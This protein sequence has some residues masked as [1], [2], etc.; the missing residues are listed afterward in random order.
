M[1]VEIAILDSSWFQHALL[2]QTMIQIFPLFH[3]VSVLPGEDVALGAVRHVHAMVVGCRQEV[4]GK[5]SVIVDDSDDLMQVMVQNGF[6]VV[7][8]VV[9][10]CQKILAIDLPVSK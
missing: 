6:H 2:D 3:Q 10:Y 7:A 8:T 1:A 4:G 5:A 9:F